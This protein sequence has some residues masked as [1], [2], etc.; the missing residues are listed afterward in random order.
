MRNIPFPKNI[1]LGVLV[2]LL[3]AGSCIAIIAFHYNNITTANRFL[4]FAIQHHISIMIILILVAIAFG[5]LWANILYDQLQRREKETKNILDIVLKFLSE[6]EKNILNFLVQHNG[7]TTQA[8]IARLPGMNRVKTFRALQK[9]AEKKL[10]EIIPHGKIRKVMLK[11][12]IFEI[13]SKEEEPKASL[14]FLFR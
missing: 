13:V 6:G 3:L 10:I 4:R 2:I 5:F 8:E 1:G 9:M 11:E 7:T 12:N 14:I